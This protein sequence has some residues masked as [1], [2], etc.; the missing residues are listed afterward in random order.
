MYLFIVLSFLTID[1][2]VGINIQFSQD[3]PMQYLSPHGTDGQDKA[4][5]SIREIVNAALYDSF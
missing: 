2:D 1:C 5:V 3:M 4:C